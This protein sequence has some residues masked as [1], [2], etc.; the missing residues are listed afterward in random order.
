MRVP[1][2]RDIFHTFQIFLSALLLR[3]MDRL[4]VVMYFSEIPFFVVIFF[5]RDETPIL[6]EEILR[7]K[8]LIIYLLEE[9]RE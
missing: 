5:P 3:D 6:L 9:A 4:F 2:E 8:T 7:K 1:R